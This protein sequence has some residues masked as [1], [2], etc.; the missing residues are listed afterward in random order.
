MVQVSAHTRNGYKVS[1]YT[2]SGG[3]T[4]STKQTKNK[5]KSK[6]NPKDIVKTG[7]KVAKQSNA[8]SPMKTG[9]PAVD[10]I[11]SKVKPIK[12]YNYGFN[13]GKLGFIL[14]ETYNQTCKKK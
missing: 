1:S 5:S 7:A 12:L 3:T 2:R 8:K 13:A 14:Q 10:K 6:C 4:K 11:A 9:N